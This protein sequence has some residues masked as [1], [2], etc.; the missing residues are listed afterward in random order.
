[1]VWLVL[2]SLPGLLPLAG[3]NNRD[4]FNRGKAIEQVAVGREQMVLKGVV[5]MMA[6]AIMAD[7]NGDY[8]MLPR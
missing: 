4:A 1:M 5:S 3:R 2:L 7:P 8:R 6:G